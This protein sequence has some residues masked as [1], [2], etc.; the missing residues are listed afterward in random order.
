MSAIT[1][2]PTLNYILT[3]SDAKWPTTDKDII[4]IN[5]L[6]LDNNELSANSNLNVLVKNGNRI[7]SQASDLFNPRDYR[8]RRFIEN[9]E[10]DTLVSVFNQSYGDI[11]AISEFESPFRAGRTVL[12]FMANKPE[13][14][15]LIENS[16][17]DTVKNQ[18]IKG[19]VALIH[20]NKIVH[21]NVGNKYYTGN[22]PVWDMT[23]YHLSQQPMFLLFFILF[24]VVI[25][26]IV[27]WRLLRYQTRKRADND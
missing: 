24:S 9:E 22:L 10:D 23:R 3:T 25:L 7:L 5:T 15:S 18:F 1:G 17:A 2:Y 26:A 27:V 14:L 8:N 16:L 6:T 13:N 12:S 21:S 4:L 20:D 11:A 19:S